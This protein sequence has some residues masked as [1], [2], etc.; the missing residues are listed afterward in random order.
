MSRIRLPIVE[1]REKMYRRRKDREDVPSSVLLNA[2]AIS[3]EEMCALIDVFEHAHA[4]IVGLSDADETVV[5]KAAGSSLIPLLYA[6][7]GMAVGKGIDSIPLLVDEAG[8]LDA[9]VINLESYEGNEAVLCSGYALLDSLEI[10]KESTRPAR[11]EHGIL[12]FS[13]ESERAPS[14]SSGPFLPGNE[15]RAQ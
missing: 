1:I 3:V 10:R 15:E 7:A 11:S 8:L 9:A 2:I 13:D 4:R 14:G 12:R 6:R 5:A